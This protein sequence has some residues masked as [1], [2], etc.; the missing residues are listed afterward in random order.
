M[1]LSE[2]IPD[3]DLVNRNVFAPYMFDGNKFIING[4]FSFRTNRH[5]KESVIWRKY[6]RS[7]QEIHDLGCIKQDNDNQ[8]RDLAKRVTYIGSIEALVGK[9]R[10]IRTQRGHGFFVEHEPSEGQHHAHV[11]IEIAAGLELERTDKED[12]R[13]EL[14]RIF[15]SLIEYAC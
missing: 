5:L 15:G 3:G 1:C 12:L 9:I 4:L 6:A 13:D 14:V 10:G 11:R 7:I 2:H 8:H